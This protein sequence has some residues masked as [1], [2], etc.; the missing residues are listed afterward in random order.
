MWLWGGLVSAMALVSFL[1]VFETLASFQ[2]VSTSSASS[3]DSVQVDGT[4][5]SIKDEALQMFPFGIQ[6]FQH[7]VH[8]QIRVEYEEDDQVDEVVERMAPPVQWPPNKGS[9]D[10]CLYARDYGLVERLGN[11]SR[12]FCGGASVNGSSSNSTYTFY[13]VPE[14]GVSATKLENFALDLRGAEIAQDIENLAD[15]G[16][17]HD[18][19][20]RYTKNSAYCS[21]AEPQDREH[22]APNVWKDY[23]AGGPGGEDPNCEAS[24]DTVGDK[25]TLT[26]AVVMVR[27][28]DHNPFFQISSILN[29]WI[30]MKTVGWEGNT[31]Q[32]V[33]LDRALP[34]PV[35]QLRHA[36][37]GPEKPVIGGEVFQDRVVHFKSALLPPYEVTGP[38]MSHLNDRQPCHAN[39]MIADF[40][41]AS[42]KSMAVA[43]RNAKTDPRRC[44]VTIISRRPYGGRRIQ[45]V[46][47]NEDDIVNRMREEYRDAYRFGVC[48]FQSLE[49]TNMTMHDQMRVMVDSDVVIGMHGAGMVNVM[50]TRPETLVIE[51]F[52]RQRYRWGYRNLC[53]Y[54]G[55]KWHEFRGGRD[56]R[57]HTSDP[58]D[59]DKFI[60]YMQ[61]RSF[62][63]PLFRAAVDRLEKKVGGT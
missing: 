34:S 26:R 28:D 47:Q 3:S 20:F 63:D 59:M 54:I 23:F 49:F 21:C 17:G 39:A 45:R 25:L 13:H 52:P 41:N 29:A 46:W 31:T 8:H 48:E 56:V 9:K 35:D 51:I 15:D 60:T 32:L 57:V 4:V 33:T 58:N 27:K 16:G 10:E 12:S 18:P 55:C 1:N 6:H 44:L 24:Q 43:P 7:E 38:L 40:R 22:G 30:M 14:A 36:L 11:S 62:F 37:L 19:R 50:W 5:K 53:Q 2:F 42:L 61:W